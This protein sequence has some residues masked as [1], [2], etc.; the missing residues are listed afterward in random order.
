MAPQPTVLQIRLNNITTCLTI[1]NATLYEVADTFGTSFIGAISKTIQ[2]L[3]SAAQVIHIGY[4]ERGRW[5]QA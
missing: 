4:Y 1:A 2:S 5:Q 3:I